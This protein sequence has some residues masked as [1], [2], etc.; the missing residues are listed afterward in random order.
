MTTENANKMILPRQ[1]DNKMTPRKPKRFLRLIVSLVMGVVAIGLVAVPVVLNVRTYKHTVALRD[2]EED[3]REHLVS[4]RLMLEPRMVI[5]ERKLRVTSL[6]VSPD[7]SA[8][9]DSKRPLAATARTKSTQMYVV[10]RDAVSGQLVRRL[11]GLYGGVDHVTLS[12][13]GSRVFALGASNPKNGHSV[14]MSALWD[15]GTGN[16]ISARPSNSPCGFS[17]DGS[18]LGCGDG[19]FDATTGKAIS[20]ITDKIVAD[21]RPRDLRQAANWSP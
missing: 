3:I 6:A 5:D 2:R 8:I 10:V 12:T 15:S 1:Y 11:R 13:D 7:G 18:R 17:P 20:V 19:V 9:L 16:L 4:V 21:C 14:A